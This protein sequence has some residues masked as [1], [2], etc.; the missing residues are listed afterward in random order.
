MAFQLAVRLAS[1]FRALGFS[2][3]AQSATRA[4]GYDGAGGGRRLRNA[5]E[6]PL[7]LAQQIAARMPLARRARY[8][9]ANNGYAAAA[10]MA[11]ESALV[12]SGIKPQ[13]AH[14]SPN[15]RKLINAAF[16]AWTR[17][18]DADGLLDFYGLQ[19]LAA[20]R[21]VVDGEVFSVFAHGPDGALRLRMVDGERLI[22]IEDGAAITIERCENRIGTEIQRHCSKQYRAASSI[23]SS[24][25]AMSS[26]VCA[27]ERNIGSN[28]L[29]W[30]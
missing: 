23:R 5:G 8:L 1:A 26:L 11:H 4:L 14:P 15:V 20:R 27:V 6:M 9:A 25:R 21:L 7:P 19:A 2:R 22:Q 29:G 24:A 17:E 30:K 3:H 12:G 13:S 18:A 10:V 28:W 16:D